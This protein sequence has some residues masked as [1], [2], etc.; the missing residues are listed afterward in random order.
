MAIQQMLLGLG[1][2]VF[3]DATGGTKSTPGDGYI[4]HLFTT[5]GSF[6]VNGGKIPSS[7]NEVLVVGGGGGGGGR[8]GGGGGAGG[9]INSGPGS[10]SQPAVDIPKGTHPVTI[11][12]GGAGSRPNYLSPIQKQY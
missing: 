2:G 11:G 6:T 1:A 5:P 9:Y 3:S 10:A 7:D 8:H 4:Y 12:N